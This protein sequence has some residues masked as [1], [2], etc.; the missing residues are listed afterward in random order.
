MGNPVHHLQTSAEAISDSSSSDIQKLIEGYRQRIS[1]LNTSAEA[2]HPSPQTQLA[3]VAALRLQD[4]HSEALEMLRAVRP[5]RSVEVLEMWADS[6]YELGKD[7]LVPDLLRESVTIWRQ[8]LTKLS[9]NTQPDHWAGTQ[10]NLGTALATL[11]ERE[12]GA[13]R[14]KEAVKAF[15]AALG[16]YTRERVP[17]DW[18]MTQNNLG[19]ALETLGAREKGTRRLEKAVSAYRAALEVYTRERV[20]LDWA[21]TQCN[22]GSALRVLGLR[23]RG[24]GRLEEAVTTLRAA[25]EVFV[26]G[27]ADYYVSAATRNLKNAEEAL[28]AKSKQN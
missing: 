17:L 11:G 24:T 21:L 25:L 20:P 14:L 2:K 9:R 12:K 1:K 28:A 26:R 22:L 8:L 18:A 13:G 4:K 10:N 6:A 23:E 27:K 3:A 7:S 15:R 16:V 19:G 5:M